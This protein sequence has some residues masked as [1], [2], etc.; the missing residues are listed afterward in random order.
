MKR[1]PAGKEEQQGIFDVMR[2]VEDYLQR[3]N[4]MLARHREQ[5]LLHVLSHHPQSCAEMHERLTQ[6]RTSGRANLFTPD[7]QIGWGTSDDLP[8]RVV[9]QM[10][11]AAFLPKSWYE[12]AVAL[13]W[14]STRQPTGKCIAV[15]WAEAWHW[16]LVFSHVLPGE[17]TVPSSLWSMMMFAGAHPEIQV[18]LFTLSEGIDARVPDT[19]KDAMLR[20]ERVIGSKYNEKASAA[21]NRMDGRGTDSRY[22]SQLQS[23]S[24]RLSN[25]CHTEPTFALKILES[26]VAEC[27][28]VQYKGAMAEWLRNRCGV[29]LGDFDA[30]FRDGLCVACGDKGHKWQFCPQYPLKDALDHMKQVGVRAGA[31]DGGADRDRDRFRGREDR[32]RQEREAGMAQEARWQARQPGR[33]TGDRWRPAVNELTGAG[34]ARQLRRDFNS[35]A[36]AARVERERSSRRSIDPSRSAPSVRE[37]SVGSTDSSASDDY[38]ELDVADAEVRDMET[39]AGSGGSRRSSPRDSGN[40]RRGREQRRR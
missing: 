40:D 24:A 3:S 28:R 25:D 35:G 29:T 26:L 20:T 17:D 6:A 9:R 37:A 21:L 12:E 32:M 15:W 13:W 19:L 14:Q 22:E 23:L 16:H 36:R 2:A 4:I 11:L 18:R 39:H 7:G 27:N 8:W 34:A 30:R 33:G 38:G 5:V 1:A 10:A 31:A